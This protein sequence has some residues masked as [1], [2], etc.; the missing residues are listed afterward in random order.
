MEITGEWRLQHYDVGQIPAL[1]LADAG[2]D[3]RFWI[4][5]RVPGD[6][7]TTL[8][9]RNLIPDPYFGHNDFASRWVEQKE[10]W[11][12]TKFEFGD[13][14][15]Q[16]E[17]LELRFEGLDTFAT[18]YVNGAELGK[19]SNMHRG[20]TFDISKVVVVG[21]N[22]IAVKFD[23][24]TP[25]YQDKALMQW[26][27]YTKERPWIRKAAMNYGWDW[28]PRMITTGIWGKVHLNKHT[29]AKIDSVFAQSIT[30]NK[31]QAEV[32]IEV[33]V[34]RY[35]P[36]AELTIQACLYD[37]KDHIVTT[38][39]FLP[40]Q[41]EKSRNGYNQ[42]A[43]TLLHVANPQLWWSHD[44]GE[45]Y[46]Y[47]L[48]VVLLANGAPVDQ[49]T[50]PFGIRSIELQLQDDQGKHTFAFLL[51]G[52]KLFAKG[53]NWIPV[54]NFIGS[55]PDK[56][57]TDLIELA[58]DSNMNMLRIWGG[59]IYE[60]DIF[61]QECDR[62]GVLVWQDFAFANALFPDYNVDFMDNVRKEAIYN[63]K[64]LRN[65]ASLALWCGN[66]EIDWLY[67]MKSSSG[68]ITC[69]FYGEAIYHE[70]LP[71]VL[72]EL[73]RSRPYWPSSPFGGNDANDPEEGD[74]HNWQVWHG[75]V[76]PRQFGE[77]PILD[78]SIEG[79]SF[80][81]Y[82]KDF[83][84]FSSE[85]GM[86]ASAN[87]Y[88]LQK[89]IP[90]GEF[91]LGSVE[92]AYRNKDTNHQKGVLLME[93]FTGIPKNIEEYMNYSML[94]QAE[95]LKYGIEHYRRNKIR[96]SGSLIWQHNDSWPGTS[97]SLIDYELLPKASYYY[98]RKFYHPLL[99]SLSHEPESTAELWVVNDRLHAYEGNVR[100]EVF[101]VDGR[102]LKQID[103][104][105]QVPAN[106]VVKLGNWEEQHLIGDISATDVIL[107]LSCSD[108]DCEDNYYYLRDYALLTLPTVTLTIAW[109]QAHQSL[110]IQ[111]SGG[112]AR[113]VNIQIAQRNIRMSDNF[114]DLLP[115]HEVIITITQ[116]DSL[117][118][119]LDTIQITA[120]NTNATY[121]LDISNDAV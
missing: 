5:T 76:Y 62:L 115:D 46:L 120:L 114:F 14:L 73:D 74:R 109:D 96:T 58:V 34:K 28:G 69:P 110:R 30:V 71:E 32:Q 41:N 64:R 91:Y 116:A 37:E 4:T 13:Q 42:S 2:L 81:N 80:K 111:S 93:G 103:S 9:E 97:W 39:T 89:Y 19:T 51:N 82:K 23:P 40:Q 33:D 54:D 119:A 21:K 36:H 75:S 53:S 105:A 22:S 84:L 44:L 88:T 7:H 35:A 100:L 65:Y 99:L 59:G 50:Q 78:Y 48:E 56:R 107:K 87:R 10:W 117:P 45:P 15:Q 43:T 98:A 108:W 86:H 12:R 49:Y 90:E 24:L 92:M 102:L 83:T 17:K 16:H 60:K 18:V 29:Q 118:L 52:I 1:H 113:M 47:R 104:Y 25:H 31:E 63:V 95:G 106:G 79:V 121:T 77:K 67:D 70:L 57:Y 6:V 112:V 68:E 61:Y 72:N 26:S 55:A 94:T 101:H 85:F 20:Y 11:Y 3:D 38:S 66:N 27:S 8:I